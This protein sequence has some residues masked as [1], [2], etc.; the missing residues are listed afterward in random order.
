VLGLSIA[1]AGVTWGYAQQ[2]KAAATLT[3][4]D[5]IEIQQLYAN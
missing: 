2:K 3:P 1:I 4:Q 5:Y